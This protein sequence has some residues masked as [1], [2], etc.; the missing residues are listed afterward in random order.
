MAF[1]PCTAPVALSIIQQLTL[2]T[3][4]V[5]S[6]TLAFIIIAYR[7]DAK[8]HNRRQGRPDGMVEISGPANPKFESANSPRSSLQPTKQ[9]FS[10]VV[11]H[12]LGADPSFSWTWKVSKKELED[13]VKSNIIS[14]PVQTALKEEILKFEV[15]EKTRRISLLNHV[16]KPEFPDARI[17]SFCYNSDWFINAPVVTAQQIGNRLSRELVKVRSTH[18]VW[19]KDFEP[20][21]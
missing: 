6:T 4:T 5:T 7:L 17:L 10:I 18:L 16:L 12:G 2:W 3:V 20:Q 19:N 21:N 8:L 9:S 13:L 14:T 1:F 11:V 15:D